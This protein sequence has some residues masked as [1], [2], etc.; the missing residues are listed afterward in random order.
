MLFRDVARPLAGLL[1]VAAAI[2]AFAWSQTTVLFN[3]G[4]VFLAMAQGLLDG[5]WTE[6]LAHPYHPLYPGLIALFSAGP[7]GLE[8]AA[9]MVS[10]LGGLL[11]IAALHR[12][13]V[14]I[15]DLE[16]AW[17]G[18][19]ILALHPWAVDFSADV[20]SDGL[21]L[22]LYLAGFAAAIA[23]LDRPSK[24]NGAACGAWIALAYWVRPEGLALAAVVIPLVLGRMGAERAYR[25][26]A[27][28]PLVLFLFALTVGI[29]PYV[30]V[31]SN[32][33]GEFTLTHKKSL[34]GL[35]EGQ[36]LTRH[37]ER[38]P[39]DAADWPAPIW[40]PQSGGEPGA[41]RPDRSLAGGFETLLRV[42]RTSAAALR[43]EV[44]LFVLIGA[45]FLRRARI[46]PWTRSAMIGP[47]LVYSALLVLLV[48]GA[49]YVSRRHALAA[50]VPWIGIAAFGWRAT[51]R[52]ILD[53]VATPREGRVVTWRPSSRVVCVA[54]VVWLT[55]IWGGRDL[56]PRREDRGALRAAA[57]WI[58][59]NHATSERIA[60]EKLRLAYYA[61]TGYV[62]LPA[63][64]DETLAAR[65]RQAGARFVVV[66][67]DRL[68]RYA[69]F[70]APSETGIRIVHRE[71]AHERQAI[72]YEL[73]P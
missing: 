51:A 11:G 60:A 16:I 1:L 71:T 28:K 56:R 38:L 2:R 42:V 46:D 37:A 9:V 18:A 34:T 12:A 33:A 35:A 24:T 63:A 59:R 68:A 66:D 17:L 52:R 27:T 25:R 13:L 57:E 73:L 36:S 14:R 45:G 19:W 3:D 54:L 39:L 10:I 4:P 32:Q 30:A 47:V 5:H 8:G 70:D 20:M 31:L 40:L 43:Y 72:V 15:F 21:Y 49:G 55:V 26:A 67:A 29:A 69:A 23:L 48:W 58:A 65:L 6:V 62:P 41:G 22:G 64:G 53:R 50:L 7:L 61:K 44:L